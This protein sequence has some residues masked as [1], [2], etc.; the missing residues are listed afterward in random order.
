MT[1]RTPREDRSSSFTSIKSDKKQ[2]QWKANELQKQAEDSNRRTQT[3][4]RL[5][6]ETDERLS[7][8]MQ[9]LRQREQDLQKVSSHWVI[10]REEIDLTGPELGV[11]A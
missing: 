4:Q 9:S 11:G 3:F 10:R 2:L 7:E 8:T 5:A 6:E 1:W